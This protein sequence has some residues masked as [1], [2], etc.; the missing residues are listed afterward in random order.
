[1]E[2]LDEPRHRKS[3]K[4]CN[5]SPVCRVC[6]E[7]IRYQTDIPGVN[8][9]AQERRCSIHPSLNCLNTSYSELACCLAVWYMVPSTLTSYCT[10][11][12]YNWSKVRTLILARVYK[13][14]VSP[15]GKSSK[16]VLIILIW[17]HSTGLFTTVSLTLNQIFNQFR[18]ESTNALLC[19]FSLI[20]TLETILNQNYSCPTL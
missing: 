12:I 8:H 16:T 3:F 13:C 10:L 17:G 1:M 11:A 15:V 7:D 19:W 4:R 14:G 6:T 9:S 20:G 5:Y 18:F 2:V